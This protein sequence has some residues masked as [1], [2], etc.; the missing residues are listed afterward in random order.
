MTETKPVSDMLDGERA[1]LEM[2]KNAATAEAVKAFLKEKEL[3]EA[4]PEGAV[5]RTQIT[6]DDSFDQL[7][8]DALREEAL[9]AHE[10]LVVTEDQKMRFLKA[11]LNDERFIDTI[12]L[13]DGKLLVEVRSRN[14]AEQRWVLDLLAADIAEGLIDKDSPVIA[15]TRF[16]YYAALLMVRR[17]NSA[18]FSDLELDPAEKPE[19]RKARFRKAVEEK[20]HQMSGPRWQAVLKSMSRF[21]ALCAKLSE[22]AINEDFWKTRA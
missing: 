14:L 7:P 12:S 11:L 21:E 4:A 8:P 13:F 1:D 15:F 3:G 19:A 9:G 20:L 5:K 10:K 22:E 18:T 16:Q 2:Q 6:P 17:I